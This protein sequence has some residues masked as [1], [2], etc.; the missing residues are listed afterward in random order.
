MRIPE[1]HCASHEVYC[2]TMQDG[3]WQLLMLLMLTS[4]SGR[5]D[6]PKAASDR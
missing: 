3:V 2:I 1:A 4:C 6:R 5:E